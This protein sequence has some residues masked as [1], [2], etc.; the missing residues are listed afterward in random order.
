[1]P[2]S[3]KAETD[4][5]IDAAAVA[6]SQW[7]QTPVSRRVQPLYK[8]VELF[9]ENEEKIARTLVEEMGKSLPDAPSGDE[10]GS[11]KLRSGL[12]YADFAGRGT[13]LSAVPSASTVR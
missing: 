11:R 4:R 1:M 9:R 12:R 6:F 8:L 3:T 10:A 13:S 7:S 2:L 5:A